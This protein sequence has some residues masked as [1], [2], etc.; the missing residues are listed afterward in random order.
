M[1]YSTNCLSNNVVNPILLAPSAYRKLEVEKGI[2][3]SIAIHAIYENVNAEFLRIKVSENEDENKNTLGS[4]FIEGLILEGLYKKAVFMVNPQESLKVL[5]NYNDFEAF[6]NIF[7]Q[8]VLKQNPGEDPL[9][10]LPEPKSREEMAFTKML[11]R[12]V[13]LE[14][15][16]VHK[17]ET[18]SSRY[19][20]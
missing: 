16:V 5:A 6:N 18:I 19:Y 13:V 20:K 15:C 3:A 14:Y 1:K 2:L 17:F 7:R 8:R 11:I 12:K 9:A 10:F 4:Y